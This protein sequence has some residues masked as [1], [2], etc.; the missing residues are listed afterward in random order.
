MFDLL[1]SYITDRRNVSDETLDLICSQFI[2]VKAR[3][4]EIL[5]NFDEVCKGIIL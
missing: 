5:I 1:K 2:L 3:R 4:N